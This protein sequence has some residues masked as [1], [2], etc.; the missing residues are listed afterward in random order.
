MKKKNGTQQQTIKRPLNPDHRL[1]TRR[2]FLA[3][4][5]ID[6]AALVMAPTVLSLL[7]GSNRA[8]AADTC[9][10]GALGATMPAVLIF[11]HSGGAGLLGQTVP[12]SFGDAPLAATGYQALGM[13]VVP[14]AADIDNSWG[15]NFH[16]KLSFLNTLNATVGA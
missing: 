10:G 1:V 5:L 15:I 9:D 12:L 8:F 3:Q 13:N 14:T 7:L 16:N 11:D 6:S 2:D 4:G